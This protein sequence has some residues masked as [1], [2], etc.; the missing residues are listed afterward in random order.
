[1]AIIKA[2][3]QHDAV[4]M[5]AF[6]S[7]GASDFLAAAA[8]A[9]NAAA[10]AAA[11]AAAR[12]ASGDA[13]SPTGLGLAAV[14]GFSGEVSSRFL[15]HDD[16]PLLRRRA[17]YC[18]PHAKIPGSLFL[19]AKLVHF[20]PDPGHEQLREFGPEEYDVLV[21]ARDVLQCGA[22]SMP[23][24]AP[25]GQVDTSPSP[26]TRL[27][28]F[29]QLHVRTLDGQTYCSSED[30]QSAW[31]VVFRLRSRE[32]LHEAARQLLDVLDAA[33]REVPLRRGESRTSVPF[34]CLDCAAEAEAL[35]RQQA[36]KNGGSVA[37]SPART[38]DQLKRAP[39]TT[40]TGGGD[41]ATP[42]AAGGGNCHS[43]DHEP[44]L[45][46]ST[47]LEQVVL[48]PGIVSQPVLTQRLAE[49][50]FDYLPISVRVPGATE[51][52]LCYTPKEHGTS[53][54]TMYRI[55]AGVERTLLV[56]QDAED[57]ILGGFAPQTWEQKGRFY[58]SGEAFVFS[59]RRPPGGGE[60]ELRIYPWTSRN[61]YFMYSD[62]ELLA[63]G[64]GEG[65]YAIAISQ[66][67]LRGHS[68][69]TPTFG[70]PCLASADEF[71][72]RDLELWAFQEAT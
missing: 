20:Q 59:F 37:S 17:L 61:S 1:M 34:P 26:A 69:P 40:S 11:R 21:E 63:M 29:L 27:A 64:G 4:R 56:V 10:N 13:S 43:G 65:H 6:G 46:F 41:A 52:V 25:C 12:A 55:A 57:N 32:E 35:W 67:L 15:P 68:A 19:S 14:L 54:S 62:S 5:R 8:G 44:P 2:V 70:N 30:S 36:K 51:W 48:R 33:R 39:S 24:E 71:V 72:V 60:P 9:A 22:V 16:P 7:G 66:D 28:Y 42:A 58:G 50:L 45:F 47:G 49:E 53:L 38:P 23:I 3:P 18:A 31:C